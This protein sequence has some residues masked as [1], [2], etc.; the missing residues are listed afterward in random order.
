MQKPDFQY[1][2]FYIT[3]KRILCNVSR[4]FLHVVNLVNRQKPNYYQQVY[5]IIEY[6]IWYNYS[7]YKIMMKTRQNY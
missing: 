1:Q 4:H 7:G 5:P 3:E 6:F 2:I